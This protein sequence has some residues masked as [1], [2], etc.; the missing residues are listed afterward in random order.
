MDTGDDRP[1]T[2]KFFA[3]PQRGD[4]QRVT[5]LMFEAHGTAHTYPQGASIVRQGEEPLAIWRIASGLA[6][7]ITTGVDGSQTMIALRGPGWLLGVN[8]VLLRKKSPTSIITASPCTLSVIARHVLE[9]LIRTDVAVPPSLLAL[10]AAEIDE[11]TTRYGDLASGS[12]RGR[13]MRILKVLVDMDRRSR[14]RSTNVKLQL[15]VKEWELAQ[16]VA[17]TPA[18]LCRL[19]GALE[20]DRLV[21]RNKGWLEILDA[22]KFAKDSEGG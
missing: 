13:L 18:H 7:C 3:A 14:Q 2:A 20:R 15:P 12:S 4:A 21:R 22:D 19:F 9:D 1:E 5:A 16:F 17:V 6:K 10:Q 8:S 11:L